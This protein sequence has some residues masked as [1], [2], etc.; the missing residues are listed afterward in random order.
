MGVRPKNGTEIRSAF[1][2]VLNVTASFPGRSAVSTC[3]RRFDA[4][5]AAVC[6]ASLALTSCVVRVDS[7]DHVTREEKRFKIQGTAEIS[8]ATF[9]GG[10]DVRGWDR[11]EVYLEI[12]RRG[13]NKELVDQLEVTVEQ[14]GDKILVDARQPPATRYAFGSLTSMSRSVKLMA[15]IPLDSHLTVRTSDGSIT[16]ERVKG[17]FE[18]R[19]ADGSITG[20]DLTGDI[21][22]HTSSGR[23]RLQTIDGQCDVETGDGSI[24]VEGRLDALDARTPDGSLSIKAF[25]GSRLTKDWSLSSGDGNIAI[26]LPEA[27]SGQLDAQT[28]D[29]HTRIDPL[30]SLQSDS[31]DRSRHILRGVLGDGSHTLRVRTLEG[32]ITFK[33][34]PFARARGEDPVER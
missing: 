1:N 14:V 12:E 11:D 2:G 9:D 17:R 28:S 5:R 23:I 26:Y 7:P 31:S 29:G 21:F 16:V 10:I 34:L 13:P 32:S 6:L 24:T 20:I 22:A 4:R 3:L 27:F 18:L 8:L 25:E 19:S 15:T 30:F 33:R